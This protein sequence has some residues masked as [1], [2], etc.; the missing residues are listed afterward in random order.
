VAIGDFYTQVT[1]IALGAAAFLGV[2]WKHYTDSID[3]LEDSGG[4]E[5]YLIASHIWVTNIKKSVEE[6]FNFI[7][8]NISKSESRDKY[9][10]LFA[11]KERLPILTDRLEKLDKSYNSYLSFKNLLPSLVEETEKLKTWLIRAICVCFA[12]AVWGATGFLMGGESSTIASYENYFWFSFA[13]VSFAGI[14]SVGGMA[15]C[16]GK[17]GTIRKTLRQEKSK[18]SA[19]VRKVT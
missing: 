5:G 13:I 2:L 11:D 1:L 15:I 10:E 19:V 8:D 4:Q 14:I 9:E 16:S 18:Y 3:K 17:C 6:F 7:Q 12:F